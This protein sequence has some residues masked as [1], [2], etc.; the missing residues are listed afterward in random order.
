MVKRK[1]KY[2]RRKKNALDYIALPRIDIDPDTRRGI[3]I[4]LIFAFGA[5][6]LLGLFDLAGALGGY[7]A[8][9]QALV[10]GWGKWLFPIIL[11]TLGFFL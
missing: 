1:R 9:F 7:L 10:F 4:M 6:C 5:I 8:H 11:L 3:I 2:K